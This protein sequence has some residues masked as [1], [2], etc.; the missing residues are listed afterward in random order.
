MS[1]DAFSETWHSRSLARGEGIQCRKGDAQHRPNRVS[2]HHAKAS[3]ILFAFR[4]E[5][6]APPA[7][8][9]PPAQFDA[10]RLV[11]QIVPRPVGV[12]SLA[13][14]EQDRV[15]FPGFSGGSRPIDARVPVPPS[16]QTLRWVICHGIRALVMQRVEIDRW[17]NSTSCAAPGPTICSDRNSGTTASQRPVMIAAP[18][19]GLPVSRVAPGGSVQSIY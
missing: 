14:V 12:P 4:R 10:K 9:K 15:Q 1:A 7:P 2:Y 6:P 18:R 8:S 11:A 3:F 19:S 13:A 5:P 17:S 16:H